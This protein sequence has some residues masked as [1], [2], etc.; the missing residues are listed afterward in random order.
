MNRRLK[1]CLVTND[2]RQQ[3]GSGGLFRTLFE[4]L[5]TRPDLDLEVLAFAPIGGPL[6]IEPWSYAL[7]RE[8]GR[9]EGEYQGAP[10]LYSGGVRRVE[11]WYFRSARG[12]WLPRARA[13][14]AV[15]AVSGCGIMAWPLTGA[16]LRYV[17]F[18]ATSMDDEKKHTQSGGFRWA[19]Y[20]AN[21]PWLRAMERQVYREAALVHTLAPA[22][23]AII[24]AE[25][26]V[27]L[28]RFR[29][30][31]VP[32]DTGRYTADPAAVR[33]GTIAWMARQSDPR[34]NT[35]LLVEAM[36][37]IAPRWPEAR[38]VLLGGPLPAGLWDRARALRVADRI[39]APGWVDEQKKIELLRQT[40]IFAIPSDQEGLCIAGLEAMA[41]GAPV[42]STRCIGPEVFVQDG[43]NGF[44]IARGDA[45]AL[46]DRLE[47]LLA[48]RP[49]RDRMGRAARQTVADRFSPAAAAAVV[50]RALA[51]AWPEK[52]G[53]GAA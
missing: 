47:R 45:A 19:L 24:S 10:A 3:G 1:V 20:Q 23:N 29:V 15:I 38:L 6:D 34:K 44:L 40:D 12:H 26:D 14:D 28:S 8:P 46:A 52:F 41:C 18:S 43:V 27:P 49:L 7:G 37:R 25:N 36:A 31:P 11:S 48:D 30:F 17:V 35:A 2:P 5:R 21:R 50:W 13:A 39:E 9:E 22:M 4:I 42:V 53:A 32:V 51:E 33:P 16:G